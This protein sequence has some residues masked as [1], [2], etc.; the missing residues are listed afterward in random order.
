M[1]FRNI[2]KIQLLYLHLE[3]LGTIN[4]LTKSL[5]NNLGR[6]DH[7]VQD[8]RV[9]SGQSTASGT[10]LLT[11]GTT[12]RNRQD[13]TLSNKNNVAVREFLFELT[14][15]SSLDLLESSLRRNRDEDDN[16]LLTSTK[17]NLLSKN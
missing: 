16:S 5:T 12:S 2:H 8:S 4:L 17:F 9:D 6:V 15:K 3:G 14:S 10:R 7:I 13:T 11:V 1:L